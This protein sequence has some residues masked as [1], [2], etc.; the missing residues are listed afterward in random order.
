MG[1]ITH[2]TGPDFVLEAVDSDT[3]RLRRTAGGNFHD[4]SIINP[5]ACAGNGNG[6]SGTMATA[7]RFTTV[8]GEALSADLCLEGSTSLVTVHTGAAVYLFRCWR[9]TGNHNVCQRYW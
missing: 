8:A 3:L 9:R 6:G 2:F 7:W 1:P 4:W 5:S